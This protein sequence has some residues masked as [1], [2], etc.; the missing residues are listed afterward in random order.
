MLGCTLRVGTGEVLLK[1]AVDTDAGTVTFSSGAPARDV[2]ITDADI[3]FSIPGEHGP[4][5]HTIN[6]FDG[7][8]AIRDPQ[9]HISG[10]H[11]CVARRF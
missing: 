5:V 7:T 10:G 4:F 11:R 6:R 1:L 2:R 3:S 9:G 8:L